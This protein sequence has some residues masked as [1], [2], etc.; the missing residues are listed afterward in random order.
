VGQL[1]SVNLVVRA[2]GD[3]AALAAPLRRTLRE[4]DPDLALA[5]VRALEDDV[6]A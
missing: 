5:R 4:I 1:R 2:E 6:R 3:P